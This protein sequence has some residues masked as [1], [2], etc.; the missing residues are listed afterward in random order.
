MSRGRLPSSDISDDRA[1]VVIT[2]RDPNL[3][4]PEIR[5]TLGPNPDSVPVSIS[6]GGSEVLGTPHP[7]SAILNTPA[8]TPLPNSPCPSPTRESPPHPLRTDGDV[9]ILYESVEASGLTE[10]AIDRDPRVGLAERLKYLPQIPSEPVNVADSNP[11]SKGDQYT[12]APRT[13]PVTTGPTIGLRSR[14]TDTSLCRSESLG[15][16]GM[17]DSLV[18]PPVFSGSS[19]QD[20][21]D[22]M[23]RFQN[24][25]IYK[26]MSEGQMCNL[27]RVMLVGNAADWLETLALEERYPTFEELRQAFFSRYRSPEVA[28]Y[29]SARDIFSRTQDEA[30]SVDSFID[31]MLKSAKVVGLAGETLQFAILHGLRP[32]IAN[33]VIQK[34]PTTLPELISAARLAELTIPATKETD[35]SLHAKLDKLLQ[36]WEESK[37]SATSVQERTPSRTQR[38]EAREDVEDQTPRNRYNARGQRGALGLRYPRPGGMPTYQQGYGGPPT[39]PPNG[40][41]QFYPRPR[42][43]TSGGYQGPWREPPQSSTYPMGPSQQTRCSK[44]GRASHSH[45]NYCPAIN[46]TCYSCGR[47]GHFSRMCRMMTGAQP[48]YQ[49]GY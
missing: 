30:E 14:F 10:I 49:T 41:Y 45:P 26:N 1:E 23:R 15:S 4:K 7:G 32:H 48:N 25:C 21:G 44:C 9:K 47:R 36:G 12:T 19:S 8:T 40:G 18:A 43:A 3:A 38:A 39:F 17:A 37:T 22:W 42:S 16:G 31:K 27:F 35:V 2:R 33:F 24:Y 46:L 34:Q 11:C 6:A 29:K 20:P 5:Y 13:Q 28:K